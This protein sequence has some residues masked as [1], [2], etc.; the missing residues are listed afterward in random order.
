VNRDRG[1]A[2]VALVT[3]LMT[4]PG[5]SDDSPDHMTAEADPEFAELQTRGAEA[6]GVDQYTSTHLF[7]ALPDGGRIELQRD[8]DDPDGVAQIRSHLREIAAAFENGDFETPAFVHMQTVPR[9]SVMAAKKDVI[10]YT[11][12]ELPRGGELRIVT[13]DAEAIRAIHAFMEFQRTDHRAG[14]EEGEPHEG[15][16]HDAMDHGAMDHDSA[17]ST[18]GHDAGSGSSREDGA[19]D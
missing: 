4:V 12:S 6:M 13:S 8:V 15:M 2:L 11:F 19:G 3:A 5:C 10:T 1:V 16:D 9:T 14:G 18:G 17:A 7:D